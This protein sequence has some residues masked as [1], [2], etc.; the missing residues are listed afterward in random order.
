[1]TEK[2]FYPI[3]EKDGDRFVILHNPFFA[4]D[5]ESAWRIGVAAR[6]VEGILY[7]FTFTGDVC[8]DGTKVQPAT[9]GNMQV[10]IID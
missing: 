6:L 2:H 1:M 4:Y 10:G 8:T 3:F 7:G 9:L 5:A